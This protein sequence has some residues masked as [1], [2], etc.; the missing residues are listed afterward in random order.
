MGHIHIQI[1]RHLIPV[2]SSESQMG[3]DSADM[4]SGEEEEKQSGGERNRFRWGGRRRWPSREAAY[5]HDVDFEVALSPVH[6]LSG[7]VPL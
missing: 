6:I 2:I 3:P 1:Y 4:H 5:R 7:P